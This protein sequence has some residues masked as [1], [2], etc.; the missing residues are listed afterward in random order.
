LYPQRDS[1][2]CTELE[3]HGGSQKDLIESTLFTAS[4]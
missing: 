1:N 4:V 2:S 3:K